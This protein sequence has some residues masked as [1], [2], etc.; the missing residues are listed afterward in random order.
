MAG[1]TVHLLV[2]VVQDRAGYVVERVKDTR[3]RSENADDVVAPRTKVAKGRMP[4]TKLLEEIGERCIVRGFHAGAV[5][6]FTEMG[7]RSPI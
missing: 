3:E 5:A 6:H 4:L 2:Y 1:V 7:H